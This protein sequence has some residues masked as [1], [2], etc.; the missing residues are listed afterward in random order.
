MLDIK[1]VLADLTTFSVGE[2]LRKFYFWLNCSFRT[3]PKSECQDDFGYSEEG[4]RCQ[5][6]PRSH[7]YKGPEMAWWA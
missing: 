6:G 1:H 3:A 5:G 4:K 2:K 7:K